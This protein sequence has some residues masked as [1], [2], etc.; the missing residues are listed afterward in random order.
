ML[1]NRTEN[2]YCKM[3]TGGDD[4]TRH[5][6]D[7]AAIGGK[8]PVMCDPCGRRKRTT[9][10]AVVCSS[11]D[12]NLC[13]E[14]R[15]AHEIYAAG[16]HVFLEMDEKARENVLVDMQGLDQC[17]NHDRPFLYICKDHDNL[18]CEYCLFDSHR[19]CQ[20]MQ[21]LK[22]LGTDAEGSLIRSVE[23]MQGAISTVQEI[24]DNCEETS[25]SNE[26]RRNEIMRDID[27]KKD[28]IIKSFDETKRR[29]GEDL[30]EFI[31]SDNIRLDE[32]K[33]MAKSV[34][35]NLQNS[36]SIT[37]D[38]NKHGTDV[39]KSILNI[40]CK[41]KTTWATTKLTQLQNSQY[42]VQHTLEWSDHL[43]AVMQEPLVTMRHVTRPSTMGTE[44]ADN[45]HDVGKAKTVPKLFR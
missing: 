37:E 26:D 15:Q 25:Q 18:C 22:D 2:E 39:E 1:L 23:E 38:V 27:N 12:L 20:D 45:D 33:N 24:I 29:I 31:T 8:M 41:Q 42:T 43:L 30:D 21:K 14:C 36:M 28:E 13:R 6:K 34:R 9:P 35:V 4:S 5:V 32:V 44:T 16:E 11:C 19:T 17:S 3:A 40:T 10:A 7:D